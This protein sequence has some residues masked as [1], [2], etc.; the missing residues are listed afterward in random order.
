MP[1]DS[2]A[3]SSSAGRA[4]LHS[5]GCLQ[6]RGKYFGEAI[7]CGVKCSPESCGLA[8]SL[9]PQLPTALAGMLRALWGLMCPSSTCTRRGRAAIPCSETYV[10]RRMW[11]YQREFKGGPEK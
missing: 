10:S 2:K 4:V 7:A 8:K 1:Q 9:V 11:K 5:V 6:G 3:M